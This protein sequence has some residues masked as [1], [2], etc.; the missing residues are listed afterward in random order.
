MKLPEPQKE[1]RRSLEAALAARRSVRQFKERELTLDE[2]SQLLWAGQGVTSP[3]GY[4]TA[5][6]AGGTLP[7]ELHLLTAGGVFCYDPRTHGLERLAD[8]D[9]RPAMAAACLDQGFV[10]QAPASIVV[11]GVVARTARIYGPRA[12]RY[13]ALEAGCASQSIMLEAVALGLGTVMIGAYSDAEVV[14]IAELP[15]GAVPLAVIPVGEPV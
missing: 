3:R 1:T 2:L 11:A 13:V 5:P 7:L 6:T 12:E 10:R 14:R 4:R 15:S 8:Q 9:R